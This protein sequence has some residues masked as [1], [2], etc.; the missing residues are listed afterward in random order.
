[1]G[2]LYFAVELNELSGVRLPFHLMLTEGNFEG[3]NFLILKPSS[4]LIYVDY[5]CIDDST[6]H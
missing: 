2:E 3:H 1:M 6:D 5:E 4:Y